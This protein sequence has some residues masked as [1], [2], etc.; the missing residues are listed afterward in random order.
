[1]QMSSMRFH[2]PALLT[3]SLHVKQ[4]S[5]IGQRI[6][7]ETN[8]AHPSAQGEVPA[9][10]L[11]AGWKRI[12]KLTLGGNSQLAGL[13]AAKDA[14]RTSRAPTKVDFS[15]QEHDVADAEGTLF[16]GGGTRRCSLQKPKDERV[17]E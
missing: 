3:T 6:R 7:P 17:S 1:M 12:E 15:Y 16:D 9:A 5:R 13:D 8:P 14:L 2:M 11:A 10:A 4:S